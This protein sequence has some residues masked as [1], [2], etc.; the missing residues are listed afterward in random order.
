[1]PYLKQELPQ[2]RTDSTEAIQ[3]FPVTGFFLLFFLSIR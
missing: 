1:M 3:F 2:K